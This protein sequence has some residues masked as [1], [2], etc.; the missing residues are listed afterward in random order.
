MYSLWC[1]APSIDMDWVSNYWKDEAAVKQDASLSGGKNN[2]YFVANQCIN[3]QK[4]DRVYGNVTMKA[5]IYKGLDLTVRGGLDITSDFRTQRQATSTQAKPNGWYREQDI[6]SK[7]FSGDFL[8]KYN[9]LFAYDI[10]LTANFGGSIIFRSYSNHS[11]TASALKI[12]GVY[13]LV[14]TAYEPLT[15][16]NSYR[17]QTNSLY[18]MVSLSWKNAIFLEATGRNDWSSTLPKENRSFFYPS[19]S[20]SVVLNDLFEFGRTNG[21]LNLLKIRA[22]WARVG[23]DT[24]PY[25]VA[26]YLQSTGFPGTISIPSAKANTNLRPEIV[27]SWEVGLELRMFKNRLDLDVAYYDAV[28]KDLISQMPVSVA[29]GVS[30]LYINAGSI[31]NRGVEASITGTLIKTRDI[32]WKV[33]ANFTLNRNTV[34]SLGE[35]I[36]S[37]IVAWYSTHAYMTAYEGGSLTAM[38]GKGYVRAPQGATAI[39]AQGNMVD[40][41]GMLVLDDQN[42]PQT[43]TDLQYLGDCAPKWKGGFNTTFKW[44][45]LSVYIGFDGQVGGNVYSYTNWVLNYRGKGVATLEGRDGSLV[46]VGVRK[47]S[48]GNYVINTSAIPKE[49]IATYYHNKYDNTNAEANFVSTQFLK[50]REVRVEYAFP[51]KL[52]AKTKVISNLSLA[53]YGNNLYCWSK[54]PGWDPEALTMRGS[55]VIPGFEILQMPTTAQ[56]G[57]SLN[58]TF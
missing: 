15:S 34:V 19:V 43:S 57:A 52:L 45:G 20:G 10:E 35:G 21:I 49:Q 53:F 48:D 3:D 30:S 23:N 46:P 5:D 31:R 1:Y 24:A 40:V 4:R 14:N 39:D 38:Y 41:S 11:Q 18:G 36:D 9:H 44:K 32:Q 54:F 50:L 2:A 37:W 29:N 7:Q 16:N 22:S 26:N 28:T 55:S 56:F 42:R 13:S 25:R 47:T 6:D 51:K 8:L 17:R 58:I 33:G 27:S 12:P